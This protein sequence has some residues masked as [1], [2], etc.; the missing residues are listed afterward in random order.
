MLTFLG[1]G[2][3][4]GEGRGVGGSFDISPLVTVW[5]NE[6]GRDDLLALG[7]SFVQ[8]DR[9][10]APFV[11][12]RNN[13]FVHAASQIAIDLQEPT[14]LIFVTK[15]GQPIGSWYA[16]SARQAMYLRMRAVLAAAGVSHVDG[17]FWHQGE[18]DENN[19]H[20][21][22]L[23]RMVTI[24]RC[25]REEGLTSWRTPIILGET[26]AAYPKINATLT[27]IAWASPYTEIAR[28]RNLP[29]SDGTH[30]TG[31]ALVTAGGLY[32]DAFAVVRQ[33]QQAAGSC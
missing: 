18:G 22:Y 14:R 27:Y 33:R 3:S 16:A 20:Q 28:L 31:P 6:N 1:M 10:A 24:W 30:F 9:D 2:Q 13:L 4:N 12:G 17:V 11:N 19:N 25:L 32:R 8:P 7:D 15:G 21:T 5:N 29:T 26:A 23:G